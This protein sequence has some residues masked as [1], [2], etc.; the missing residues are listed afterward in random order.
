MTEAVTRCTL[1]SAA[2]YVLLLL[3]SSNL[4]CGPSAPLDADRTS[5][6]K[7]S[8]KQHFDMDTSRVKLV[9]PERIQLRLPRGHDPYS[10]GSGHPSEDHSL[11]LAS[12]DPGTPLPVRAYPAAESKT[13]LIQLP[14][15][16]HNS[17]DPPR[18]T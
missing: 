6:N 7:T 5:A 4:L 2:L 11:A 13:P 3:A 16:A 15:R 10:R 14:F 8:S 18:A 12:L 17:R 1:L 9:R